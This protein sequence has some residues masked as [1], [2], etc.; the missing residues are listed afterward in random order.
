MI[1]RIIESCARYR[2]LVLLLA[3]VAAAGGYV[4]MQHLKVDA[5]PDLSDPQVIVFSEW[6][7]RSPT[8]IEDQVTYPLVSALLSVPKVADVRGQ[9]MFGM[10]FVYVVFEEGCDPYWARSRVLEYL[11]SIRARLPA[12]VKTRIGPDA[13]GVG[14]IY[15]YALVDHRRKQDLGELRALHDFSLRYALASVKGVAEV[16]SVGG[17]EAQYQIRVDPL[18]LRNYGLALSD[19]IRA[20]QRS[21]EDVGARTL[22]LSEREYYIRGR[23]FIGSIRDL[24]EVVVRSDARGVPLRLR[25]VASVSMGGDIR[26]GAADLDGRGEVVSG[27][28]VMRQ[29]ENALEVIRRVEAKIHE[30]RDSLPEGVEFVAVY[31]RAGLIERSLATLK[32]AL[33]EEMVVVAAVILLFLLH[34]RSALLPILSLPLAVLLAFIPMALFDVPATIMSL[35]GIAIA[36]GATVDAEIVMIEASHKKLE[37]A[38]EGLSGRERARL[39]AEAAREVTPAIF[40]SLLIVA[41]SFLPIFALGGQAGRLFRPLAATKT[42]V[43]LAAALVSITVAPALRDLL[44]RGKVRSEEN[45]PVS[46]FVR[47]FY[48]PFVHVA[49]QR[50]KTTLLIGA[51]AAL[52]TLPLLPRL[53]SEF[54]PPLDE[55]DLL[56]MP[57]TLPNIS[58][59]RA[60]AELQRQ[61]AILRS[62]PEVERVLGKVGRAETATDPAPLS[63]VETLVR[64]KPRAQWR[65]RYVRRWYVGRVPDFLRPLLQRLQ[66]EFEPMSLDDLVREMDEKLRAPGW[67]N[68]FTQPIRNRVDM[69]TTGIR[70]PVGIKIF[71]QKLEDIEKT[72]EQIEG[73]LRRVQGTRNVIYERMT[74][75]LYLDILPRRD[76]LARYGLQIADLNEVIETALGGM[77]LTTTVEGRRR[78]TVNLRYASDFRASLEDIR[79]VAIPLPRS[80][81]Q[82]ERSASIPLGSVAEVQLSE[83]PPMLRDEGGFFIDTATTEIYTLLNVGSYVTK[84][85]KTLGRAQKSGSLQLAEGSHLRWTGQFEL[86]Q[87]MVARMRILVPLTLLLVLLLLY[88]QFRNFSEVIIV[89][90]SVPFALV[91]SVW[92]LWLL[93]Y[94]VSTAV[95]VGLIA[96]VGLATQTGVV[97]IVYIDQ[98]YARRLQAGRIES[99]EDIIEAHAE[100]TV[101]R[102]RP[103]LMTVGTMLIGLVPLLWAQGSGADVMKRIAAPMVG[104]LLSSAFLTLELIP[105]VYTYWRFEQLIWRRAESER[106][107]QYRR[108]ERASW[109]S[110]LLLALSVAAF[111]LAFFEPRYP[112]LWRALGLSLSVAAPC[113]LGVYGWIRHKLCV[114]LRPLLQRA[115]SSSSR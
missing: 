67:T 39:L 56:Y 112:S 22:E 76:Q 60:K 6:P 38:P 105:V 72:G 12:T 89:L 52:S 79:Q 42:F 95:W 106:P 48:E 66:P 59:E 4:A 113:A 108:L 68:A 69:L 88:A 19:L 10:S 2:V 82:G 49:L 101:Q 80:E 30:L 27:I 40:F 5:I 31:E 13:S 70:T 11:D 26:R 102:V 9:S 36:L 85:Q 51:F 58:I 77:P 46:R 33:L 94:H 65:T 24:E 114:E 97:M 62:F 86:L 64:L 90:L 23:G 61:D 74:G 111:A 81:A 21:N 91:G 32:H 43:M 14:W 96:L 115:T 28:V 92:A 25:D 63:M 110:R 17:F 99:L 55:G 3:L 50:P 73:L 29:G 57:T 37:A 35:G 78:H 47:A 93:D 100:G 7:G 87:A 109:A 53:G 41:V 75:G 34:F 44:L 20:V 8:L 107:S 104:G 1:A 54:M 83:G 71:G 103:K 15:Q 16:A 45:H 98:A 84:A 18:R